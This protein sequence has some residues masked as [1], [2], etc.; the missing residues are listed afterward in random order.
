MQDVGCKMQDRGYTMNE[1]NKTPQLPQTNKVMSY[2][3]LEIYQLAHALALRVHEMTLSLP[4]F[5]LYEEGSQI[6]RSAKSAV[7]NI[8]EGFGRRRYKWSLFVTSCLHM[9]PVMKPLS[10]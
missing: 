5:E 6:R 2:R 9:L 10:I 4:K 3:D 7:A 1:A 8:V